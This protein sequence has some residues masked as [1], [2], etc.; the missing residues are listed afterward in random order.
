[1]LDETK[2]IVTFSN[3]LSSLKYIESNEIEPL[4][5]AKDSFK[6]DGEKIKYIKKVEAVV[7]RSQ[8]DSDL[9][10][11]IRTDLEINRCTVLSAL[12]A[13]KV[14]V[15][16]HHAPFT[17]FDIVE[18][19]LNNRINKGLVFTT[20]NLAE[21][22]LILHYEGLV[23][24][25]PLSA[26][27]HELVHSGGMY[28]NP[29]DI[30]GDIEGFVTRYSGNLSEAAVEKIV[31]FRDFKEDDLISKSAIVFDNNKEAEF[32]AKIETTNS[33]LFS[34]KNNLVQNDNAIGEYE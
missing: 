32:K 4:F 11:Y 28:V 5:Y 29:K 3:E 8:E 1:M 24:L 25:T 27:I 10:K 7:R 18:T 26:T 6:D 12:S 14:S 30:I 2:Q 21:E 34:S 15:E 23:G 31:S 19:I 9:I 33:I 22:V 20:L 13:G 16:L 17:L